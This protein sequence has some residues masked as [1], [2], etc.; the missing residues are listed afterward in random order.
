MQPPQPTPDA[1]SLFTP[2]GSE[3]SFPVVAVSIAAVAVVLLVGALVLLGRRP[4]APP[5]NT[6]QPAA[7]YAANLPLSNIQMSESTSFSG[8]K[9]TYV[10]GHIGNHGTATITGVTVQVV[11]ANDVSLPPQIQTV[12]LTLIGMRQPYIDT[13]PVSAAPLTPAAEADF[14]LILDPINQDW[15]QQQPLIRVIHVS[16]R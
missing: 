3:H 2:S 16:T 5:P 13:E 14:R 15:N 7:A 10:D 12:P 4:P 8:S 6:L 1:K 11:F 9:A